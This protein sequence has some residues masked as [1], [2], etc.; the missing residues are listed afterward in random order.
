MSFVTRPFSPVGN[1]LYGRLLSNDEDD[2]TAATP[3][4]DDTGAG[5]TTPEGVPAA[6]PR[7]PNLDFQTMN[8]LA[9]RNR[10]KQDA[11][12]PPE[13]VASADVWGSDEW[14]AAHPPPAP[15][16]TPTDTPAVEEPA[17]DAAPAPTMHHVMRKL[18]PIRPA[19]VDAESN[20]AVS[21][22]GRMSDSM[23]IA[24]RGTGSR[25]EEFA[26]LPPDDAGPEEF[27]SLPSEE[28]VGAQAVKEF[29]SHGKASAGDA[30]TPAP[31]APTA[32]PP[33]SRDEL[34]RTAAD[35]IQ[36]RRGSGITRTGEAINAAFMRRKQNQAA[37]EY[38]DKADDREAAQAKGAADRQSQLAKAAQEIA[39]RREGI[40]GADKRAANTLAQA[41]SEGE[42]N[43]KNAKEIA[44]GHD[45][46]RPIPFP[47]EM[48]E[49]APEKVDHFTDTFGETQ[50]HN[51]AME[52]TAAVRAARVG[53]GGAGGTPAL[54]PEARR[55][56][57]DTVNRTGAAPSM[58][59]GGAG[60]KIDFLNAAG[61]QRLAS[62]TPV[63][64]VMAG[65]DFKSNTAAL[66][67]A[68]KAQQAV[69]A[70]EG[71]A[72]E[73]LKLVGQASQ[74]FDR[75]DYPI[76]NDLYVPV[77]GKVGSTGATNLHTTIETA[78][79]EY[80]KV[81]TANGFGGVTS[82]SARAH[83]REMLN[84]EMS[85]EQ[86]VSQLKLLNREMDNRRDE[87]AR[88]IEETRAKLGGGQP[89]PQQ[90]EATVPVIT[91]DGKKGR[92]PASKL[93]EALARGFKRADG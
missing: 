92:V 23:S 30:P 27:A 35:E 40:A 15:V 13:S 77:A 85:H 41:A 22:Q 72:R 83:A 33:P 38:I 44:A 93:N 89:A 55:Q 90:P 53:S 49:K 52:H 4:P 66:T 42:K 47:K 87:I 50:R 32:K 37:G 34:L 84:A 78:I 82:D 46:S 74:N 17:P 71:T 21:S 19:P 68:V 6:A 43:R 7:V 3:A 63:D 9:F 57:G 79:N 20:A 67:A 12:A 56:G 91:P 64:P 24:P 70:A 28:D 61:E 51:K 59:M 14:L 45:D 75:S 39:F 73:N 5:L 88:T 29:S 65:A 16:E 8:L 76:V 80:A 1:N 36:G 2:D 69:S 62:P 18:H 48:P 26:S 58:G 25:P 10:Q 86:I 60:A 31:T 54:S 11:P 81:M